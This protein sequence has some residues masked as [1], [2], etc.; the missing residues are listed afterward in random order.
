MGSQS[1]WRQASACV[2]TDIFTLKMESISDDL[3]EC[4][5]YETQ[6]I[7]PGAHR[8]MVST[9]QSNRE[10]LNLQTIVEIKSYEAASRAFPLSES[11]VRTMEGRLDCRH[12][13][14]LVPFCP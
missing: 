14:Q 11:N 13:P 5:C 12:H 7:R 9:Y 2:R 3:P 1:N 8:M 6:L 10:N 4:F